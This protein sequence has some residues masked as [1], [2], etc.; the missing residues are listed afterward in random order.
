MTT[1]PALN[2][3]QLAREQGVSRTT[4]RRRLAAG[5]QPSR[6]GGPHGS[7]SLANLV[8]NVEIIPPSTRGH[9]WTASVLVVVAFGIA[10]LAVAIN[11]QTGWSFGTSPM[12]RFTFAGV[13][14]AADILAVILPAAAVALWSYRR[15]VL[16]TLAW[17]TWTAVAALAVLATLGFVERHVGDSAAGRAAIVTTATVTADQHKRTIDAAQMAAATATAQ[18]Q[19]ECVKR[20]PLCRERE[21]DERV[22]LSGLRSA[23]AVPLPTVSAIGTSDPQSVGAQRLASWVG[24]SVTTADV[25]NMRLALLTLIPN[26]AGLVLAFG[27]ALLR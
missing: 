24:L 18:R 8:A 15:P 26:I 7:R 17:T 25:V 11:A 3:S 20:G 5:W 22:A 13:S 1:V 27:V 23:L 12:A 2:I 10:A 16:A 21:A 4:I 6:S 9:P 14:V 19:A